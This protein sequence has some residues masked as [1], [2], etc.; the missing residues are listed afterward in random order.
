MPELPEVEHVARS[1]NNLVSGRTIVSARLL[2]ERLAPDSNPAAFAKRLKNSAINFIHRRGKHI[3][4]DLSRGRTL[5]THLRMTGSFSLHIPDRPDPKFTH[6]IFFLDNDSR[7]VFSDQ[8][9]FGLMK[10]VKTKLL[11][12]A[13]ELKKLAPEPFSDAF[14]PSYVGAVLRESKRPVK[15]L[16]LDQTKFC[17]L[18]N[19]YA[20]EA[21]F[22]AAIGPRT[23]SNGLSTS[24]AAILHEAVRQVLAEAIEY[25]HSIPIDAENL[26]RTYFGE[27]G[28]RVYDREGQP[29]P[30]CNKPIK[31][32]KQGGRS[33]F[34]CPRCQKK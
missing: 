28:W 15:E 9:H 17:G 26:E 34:Y 22:L 6:A 20:A 16:L 8:R 11:Y 32:I 19:I 7:L 23:M 1:L 31:R 13:P 3:L 25:S 12:E 27:N 18:G 10:I 33:T 24:K 21:L 30:V 4:F 2:R 29:C 14:S 5:I